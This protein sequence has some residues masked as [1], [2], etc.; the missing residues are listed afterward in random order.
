MTEAREVTLRASRVT[1]ASAAGEEDRVRLFNVVTISRHVGSVQTATMPAGVEATLG[2][3]ALR[4]RYG[5]SIPKAGTR[6]VT[7]RN[8]NRS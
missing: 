3:V 7:L 5:D 6:D 1:A 2:S 4:T 8:V